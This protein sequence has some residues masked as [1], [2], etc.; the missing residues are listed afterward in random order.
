MM[1][2]IFRRT[3][4][5]DIK[6]GDVQ[7]QMDEQNRRCVY[8]YYKAE[9]VFIGDIVDPIHDPLSGAFIGNRVTNGVEIK[10]TPLSY[11]GKSFTSRYHQLATLDIASDVTD[12][13]ELIQEEEG[14]E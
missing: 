10:W 5:K 8:Y 1:T 2:K 9:S 4:A 12:V 14:E 11:D 7:Q 13:S 6:V 3:E